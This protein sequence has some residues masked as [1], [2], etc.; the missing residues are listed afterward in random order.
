MQAYDQ[1]FALFHLFSDA[2]SH[3]RGQ[4]KAS[5]CEIMSVAH[6]YLQMWSPPPRIYNI[7]LAWDSHKMSGSGCCMIEWLDS[8]PLDRIEQIK[9]KKEHT[10][11]CLRLGRVFSF[12]QVG[13][14]QHPHVDGAIEVY[15]NWCWKCPSHS[16][17]PPWRWLLIMKTSAMTH[18]N[19]IGHIEMH[20]LMHWRMQ[21]VVWMITSCILC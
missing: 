1:V 3:L 2:D 10:H 6:L 13:S 9:C 15:H 17:V 21:I 20:H 19:I 12:L 8:P 16:T 7:S 4:L 14:N 18:S 5:L 11:C